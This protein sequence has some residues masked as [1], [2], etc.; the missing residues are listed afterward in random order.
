RMLWEQNS[1][2]LNEEELT[3]RN[4][5]VHTKKRLGQLHIQR[6]RLER[7][8]QSLA[9]AAASLLH[10]I[11]VQSRTVPSMATHIGD[12]KMIFDAEEDRYAHGLNDANTFVGDV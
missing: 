5:L 1:A 3:R 10:G 7:L 6:E 9:L 12:E 4:A 2:V 11:I 8:R